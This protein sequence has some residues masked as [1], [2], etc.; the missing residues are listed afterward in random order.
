[1]KNLMPKIYCK[2]CDDISSAPH[3]SHFHLNSPSAS[4]T[5]HR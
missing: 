4:I 5:R 1:M 2:K 3:L